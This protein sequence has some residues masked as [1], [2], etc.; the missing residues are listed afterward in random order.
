MPTRTERLTSAITASWSQE[1]TST[2]N[3][4]SD[5]LPARG[6]CV[7]TSLVVQDYLGGDIERLATVHNGAP[8]THY[9]NI[10][11]GQIIDLSRSQYPIGQ[12][13][14]PAPPPVDARE[15]VMTNQNTRDRY[16][17]LTNGVQTLMY[18]Q[19]MAEHPEDTG[20]LTV[21]FDMDGNMFD[22][23]GR[24]EA[25]LEKAGYPV[26]QRTNFYMTK[27]MSDPEQIALVNQVKNSK[28]F[29]ESLQPIDGAIEAWHH[30]KSLGFHPRICSAPLTSN[31]WC[32][33]EKLAS[34]EKHLGPR[35]ADEAFISKDK[36][37][38]SGIALLDDRPEIEDAANADWVHT[39]YTQSYN[40]HI[41]NEYRIHDWTD[42]GHLERV[43][44]RAAARYQSLS[45]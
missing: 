39:H 10:I 21:L 23:D 11:G 3:E 20:K 35:A 30:T 37:Q 42:L 14:T 27:D 8:E 43:L 17:R 29:F 7:P 38:C 32:I 15:Y 31:P 9:R 2:P 40:R 44:A 22:F 24:L 6:Q 13:F 34:V 12:E 25:E 1:T 5:T 33:A 18:L 45:L 4:W 41:P 16:T 19:S 36:S 28:G 26:P